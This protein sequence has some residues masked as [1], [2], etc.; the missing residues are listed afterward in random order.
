MLGVAIVFQRYLPHRE[1]DLEKVLMRGYSV[2]V[3][4]AVL[5]VATAPLVEEI[6]YRGVLYGGIERAH[7]RSAAIVVATLLF[8]LG[9]FQQYWGSVASMAT[10]FLLSLV[11][12]TL[13]AWT[14]KLLPCVATHLVYNAIQAAILLL[15]PDEAINSQPDQAALTIIWRIL[16]LGG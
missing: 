2:R 4:I 12:T 9:H 3:M 11:L 10:I 15:A 6:V 13:R 7:G 16:V 8:A 14:G 5:A 1:T